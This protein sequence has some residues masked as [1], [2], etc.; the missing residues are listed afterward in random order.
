MAP[1]D[2]L[3]T[4]ALADLRSILVEMRRAGVRQVIKPEVAVERIAA[5]IRTV[6][7]VVATML[8]AAQ[9]SEAKDA[10]MFMTGNMLYTACE[11]QS[12]AQCVGYVQAVSDALFYGNAVNGYRACQPHAG[13]TSEQAVDVVRRWLKDHPEERHLGAV[14]LTAAALSEAFPC[15]K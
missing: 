14:G 4:E 3:P 2:M 9:N 6:C 10:W 15:P 12:R 1:P 7:L 8:F 13:Y 11:N 5:K